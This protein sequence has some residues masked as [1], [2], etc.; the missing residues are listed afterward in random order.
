MSHFLCPGSST[1][2]YVFG[3]PETFRQTSKTLG[4]EVLAEVPLE[5]EVSSRGDKGWP[6]VMPGGPASGVGEAPSEAPSGGARAAFEGLARQVWS[7]LGG[8]QA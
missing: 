5:A 8:Q 4:L 3:P 2:H 1:P 6:A 7:R